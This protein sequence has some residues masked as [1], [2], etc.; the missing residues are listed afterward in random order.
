VN[1][2]SLFDG[3]SCGYLA[4]EKAKIPITKY[5]AA[6]IDK[7]AIKIALKNHLNIIQLGDVR[8]IKGKDLGRIDLLMGGSPCQSVSNAGNRTG[9]EGKSGLFFEFLRL[10]KEIN[11]KYFL[12]ENVK[13]KK[14]WRNIITKEIGAEPIEIDSALVSAQQRKRLYWTNI[15][16]TNLKITDKKIYLKDI[17]GLSVDKT[18]DK[19]CMT[20]SDFEV[21]VRKNYIDTKQL[22]EYLRNFKKKKTNKQISEYCGV[23]ITKVEHWFRKDDSSAIPDEVSWFKL[24]QI[25]NIASD[26]FDK[27]ITE[28]EIKKNNFDMAK[29]IYHVRGKHP[30][31][32]TL[33]GGHQRKTITDG[34]EFFYLTPEHA[35]QLQT[36]PIGYTE[37]LSDN[38]RFAVIGNGW[39]VDIIAN[40]LKNME[41]KAECK[42]D[43]HDDSFPPNNK[44]LGIQPTIL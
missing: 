39:T 19:I 29:R 9:F 22:V 38:Q 14:E 15:P 35:E 40:I 37:G 44:L 6:E 1:I 10:K 21:K 2:L 3:I 25:L 34:K 5:F 11:P 16:L 31:L 43:S 33:S 41:V 18:E 12:L 13:M 8:N 36:L 20:K 23:P 27:E 26:K 4:L 28:F 42:E 30:T 7:N 32:T 17:L 24:K